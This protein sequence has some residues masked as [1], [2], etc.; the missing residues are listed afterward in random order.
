MELPV[1]IRSA[2]GMLAGVTKNIGVGGM[3]VAIERPCRVGQQLGLTF[4]LPGRE[5]P[6]SVQ[7]EVRWI[8]ESAPPAA[9]DRAAGMGL[10]F[11][12]LPALASALLEEFLEEHERSARERN[13]R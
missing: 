7:S 3:F 6:I 13:G 12:G 10:W 8:R 5:N 9:D 2:E 11:V 4:A 1:D